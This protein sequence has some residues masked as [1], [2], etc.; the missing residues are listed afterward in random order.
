MKRKVIVGCVA[1]GV[2]AGLIWLALRTRAHTT[3][4]ERRSTEVRARGQ[5]L[6]ADLR[7]AVPA[8]PASSAAAS[9]TTANAPS[10]PGTA[11]NAATPPARKRPPGL[12]DLARDNPQLMNL[13]IANQRSDAQQRY[14][15]LFQKLRLTEAQ[16]EK[17]KDALAA[18]VARG[19]DLGAAATERGISFEDP[20]I[21]QMHA[22]SQKQMQ[23]EL[24]NLLGESAFLA[25]DE[26]ERGLPVRGFVDGFAVQL[27]T[28]EPLSAGQA[29]QLAQTLVEASPEFRRG[30]RANPKTVDW[31]SVDRA[32]QRF[33]SPMQ[34]ASWQLGVAHNRSG[35][36]RTDLE[37]TRIYEIA[38]AKAAK[39]P[40][41]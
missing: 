17:F 7:R 5:Q 28:I 10:A 4:L 41:P 32:V 3:E 19:S 2:L 11:S 40:D 31:T 29:E 13:W 38:K 27:A 37:L 12:L 23:A 26:F 16:Q 1:L 21:K 35:G 6:Q 39:Q 33:L 8:T 24:K 25:Y 14:G 9:A 20:V 36:S 22:D 30:E 18:Y 15:A 34:L